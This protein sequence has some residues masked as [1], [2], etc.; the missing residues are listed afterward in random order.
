M[1][2]TDLGEQVADALERRVTKEETRVSGRRFLDAD[3]DAR[4]PDDCISLCGF[5]A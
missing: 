1:T 5:G 3:K 2:K 4:A